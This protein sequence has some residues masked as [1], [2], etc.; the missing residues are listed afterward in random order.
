[1]KRTTKPGGVYLGVGPDQNFTYIVALQP[2]IVFIFDIR[3]QNALMHLM[4]KSLM[5]QSPTRADFVSRLLSRPKPAGIDTSSTP[6]AMFAAFERV[7][8]DSVLFNRTSAEIERHLTATHNFALNPDDL[9]AIKW[10]LSQFYSLG[11]KLTYS[12]GGGG[13]R[14]GGPRPM[15]SYSELQVETDAD[16]VARAYLATEANY[17]WLREL[18]SK[19]LLIPVVGDFGGPKAIRAVGKY[20]R[21]HDATVTAFYTSNVEQYL[22]QSDAWHRFFTNVGTLPLD[23]SSTFIRAVFNQMGR[24]AFGQTGASGASIRSV[25][26]LQPLADAVRAFNEGRIQIYY[27]VILMSR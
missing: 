1:L 6:Q 22:F 20:L 3:R 13:G 17:Q 18:Q 26:M 2:K 25:T 27:D 8:T 19:N 9:S 5:E 7:P 16:G 4:Y 11:P 12:T 15:P 23:S 24:G 10:V 21:D 14:G